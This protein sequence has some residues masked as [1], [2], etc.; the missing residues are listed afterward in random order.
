MQ[1][2]TTVSNLTFGDIQLVAA[3]T[4][5]KPKATMLAIQT[6]GRLF[7]RCFFRI[8]FL[9]LV[10]VLLCSVG[11]CGYLLY[12][13]IYHYQQQQQ[14]YHHHV[15]TGATLGNMICINNIISAKVCW[16][17][18]GTGEG[19]PPRVHIVARNNQYPPPSQAVMNLNH[20]SEGVFI[21]RTGPVAVLMAIIA[22]AVGYLFTLVF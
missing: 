20:V 9:G 19:T 12:D 7:L 3:L 14:K 18:L 16:I 1:G 13:A 5:N 4:I 15:L 8:L 10:I 17:L 21:A 11:C 2:S 6:A 22:T